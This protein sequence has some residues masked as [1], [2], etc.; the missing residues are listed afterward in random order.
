M[1]LTIEQTNALYKLYPNVVRTVGDT[2]YN[3]DGNVVAYD[4][5]LVT[6]QAQKDACKEKAKSLLAQ[7]D[8]AVLSDVGLKNS[9]DFV[10]Y[11]GILRGLVLQPQETPDFPVEPKAVWS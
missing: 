2:A 1:N 8:W 10:T 5:A 6:A 9:A 3:A 4:L 11:R 7:T